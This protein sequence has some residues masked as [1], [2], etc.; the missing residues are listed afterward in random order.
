MSLPLDLFKQTFHSWMAHKAPKM[1]AALA[2]YTVF[3]LAPMLIILLSV[4]SFVY[5]RSAARTQLLDQFHHLLGKAG[6][7][8]FKT[9][10]TATAE[11]PSA[12]AVASIVGVVTLVFGA[13]G[14]FAELQDSLN[15]IWEVK[16]KAGSSAMS[17]VKERFL[18][19]VMVLGT[20][21]LLLTSLVLTAAVAAVNKYMSTYVSGM[22]AVWET[23]NFVL[24]FGVITV[25][26]AMIFR[27]LPDIQIAWKDVWIGA[28]ITALLFDIGKFLLGF[29]LGRSAIGSAYGAAGS[30][31]ILLFWIYYT[32]QI[33]F[34]G[35]E[36]TRAYA[37]RCGT[38]C[39][40]GK[41][42]AD[43]NKRAL[44]D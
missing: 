39:G 16:A 23:T 3:S 18:S 4:A 30:L 17:L 14:V 29:Y 42:T 2:Y 10:L 22:E 38:H 40:R 41:G 11:Q 7:D 19:F 24:T 5:D 33:L 43:D 44:N 15:T 21:F 27:T 26:F 35:A 34:F 20:G 32:S 12:G 9:I 37:T 1:G 6:S 36:F 31:I 8:V 25:L 13:S 28:A